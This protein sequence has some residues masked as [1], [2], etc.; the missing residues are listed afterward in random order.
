MGPPASTAALSDADPDL[1]MGGY[2]ASDTP[3]RVQPGIEVLAAEGFA[4]LKGK[5]VGV[6]T[7]Q[8]GIDAAGRSTLSR[9]LPGPRGQG[10]GHLQ[11]G[12]R[13][14]RQSR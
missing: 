3:D 5:N 1:I 6:I 2:G 12:A 14:V 7:N 9:L 13:P 8:T 4:S 10:A 11:P